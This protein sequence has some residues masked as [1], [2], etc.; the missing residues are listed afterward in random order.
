MFI[1]LNK[2][3]IKAHG[4]SDAVAFYNALETTYNIV[5]SNIVNMGIIPYNIKCKKYI[6]YQQ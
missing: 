4:N 3:V 5:K 2:V 6:N 1:G